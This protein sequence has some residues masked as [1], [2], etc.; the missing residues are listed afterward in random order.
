MWR[1]FIAHLPD[2]ER[3]YVESF[4]EITRFIWRTLD[5][6]DGGS[7]PKAPRGEVHDAPEDGRSE[8]SD[9]SGRQ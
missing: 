2:E 5:G 9:D 3:I 4:D 6:P 1:G 8:S 7:L